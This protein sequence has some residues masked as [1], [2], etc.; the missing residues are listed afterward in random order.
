MRRP[1]VSL[2]PDEQA[3]VRRWTRRMLGAWIAVV[4]ATVSL[5]L[6]ETDRSS[7]ARLPIAECSEM[8]CLQQVSGARRQ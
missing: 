3:A 1:A 2:T 6:V 7:R 4:V 8:V 5:S